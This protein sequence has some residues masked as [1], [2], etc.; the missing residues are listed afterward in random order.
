[1]IKRDNYIT[2]KL[3]ESIYDFCK[4]NTKTVCNKF[5]SNLTCQCFSKHYASVTE[6][7]HL[8]VTGRNVLFSF[9]IY[10]K[11]TSIRIPI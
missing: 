6:A 8:N 4:V 5:M 7:Y 10:N 9:K 3:G 1:M 2:F 11:W